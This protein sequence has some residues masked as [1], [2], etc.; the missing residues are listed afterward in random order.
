MYTE[1]T[2]YQLIFEEALNVYILPQIARVI[3]QELSPY[4][5]PPSNCIDITGWNSGFYRTWVIQPGM[6]WSSS[7]LLST[8]DEGLSLTVVAHLVKNLPAMQET[9]VWFLS[10]EDPLEKGKATHS[11]ILAH[12]MGCVFHGVTKSWTL[13]SNFH[14]QAGHSYH[15]TWLEEMGSA[16]LLH[17]EGHFFSPLTLSSHKVESVYIFVI[18]LLL[19]YSLLHFSLSGSGV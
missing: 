8:S 2:V 19:F 5:Q 3:C 15:E 12:S 16:S 14:I 13:L 17:P 4:R 1:L 9:P 6:K 11:S 10:Q 7:F 18:C